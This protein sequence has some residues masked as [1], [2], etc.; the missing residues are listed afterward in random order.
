MRP[1]GQR[2]RDSNAAR[3]RR[4]E[5]PSSGKTLA[6]RLAT[7]PSRLGPSRVHSAEKLHPQQFDE[8]RRCLYSGQA[9]APVGAGALSPTAAA[10]AP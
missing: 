5:T 10:A 1:A 7:V 8:R 4:D 3:A 9:S 6:T 2:E